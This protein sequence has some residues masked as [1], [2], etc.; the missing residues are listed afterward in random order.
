MALQS[1]ASLAYRGRVP[2]HR[3][4]SRCHRH[5]CQFPQKGYGIHPLWSSPLTAGSKCP[6]PF[7]A[8]LMPAAGH[9][10]VGHSSLGV[11]TPPWCS[12]G[13]ALAL[14]LLRPGFNSQPGQV[15]LQPPHVPVFPGWQCCPATAPGV[16]F[17]VQKLRVCGAGSGWHEFWEVAA[18]IGLSGHQASGVI[19]LW[20]GVGSRA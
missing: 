16:Q 19:P 17:R 4:A 20:W 18:A 3:G 12:S 6:C 1:P 10:S 2:L 5:P 9:S 8:W 15:F 14:S 7:T 11:T 13:Q